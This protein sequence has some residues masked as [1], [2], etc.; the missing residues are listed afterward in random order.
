M[1]PFV[2]T[3][4]AWE[5]ALEMQ[6]QEDKMQDAYEKVS[7]PA[8]CHEQKS[9]KRFFFRMRQQKSCKCS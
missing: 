8:P 9:R 5:K 1:I 4:L 7:K 6:L 3:I 2:Y